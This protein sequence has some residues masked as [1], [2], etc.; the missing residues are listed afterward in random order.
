VLPEDLDEV[1]L[2]EMSG[3]PADVASGIL[4]VLDGVAGS[5]KVNAEMM[6][7]EGHPKSRQK[8]EG[9][10]SNGLSGAWV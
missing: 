6:V 8:T 4:A 5:A 2:D 9:A 7:T 3:I 10:D 1:A